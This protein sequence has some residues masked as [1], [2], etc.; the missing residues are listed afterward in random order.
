MTA[1][2]D[3]LTPRLHVRAQTFREMGRLAVESHYEDIQAAGRKN[4]A[5][6]NVLQEAADEINRYA[7]Q[8]R[9]M[10]GQMDE[11]ARRELVIG[12]EAAKQALENRRLREALKV[13]D[14]ALCEARAFIASRADEGWAWLDQSRAKIRAAISSGQRAGE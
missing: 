9:D 13:A 10:D 8:V 14:A 12:N 6:A 3:N 2:T 1:M 5:L 7:A 4:L 11:F